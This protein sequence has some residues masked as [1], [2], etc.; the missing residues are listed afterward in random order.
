M[1]KLNKKAKVE[2]IMIIIWLN[3]LMKI[4]LSLLI[5]FIKKNNKEKK[6]NKPFLAC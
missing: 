5:K 3:K 1:R 6:V 4:F 2:M